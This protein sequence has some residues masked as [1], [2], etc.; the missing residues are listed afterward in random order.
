MH[1]REPCVYTARESYARKGPTACT[2]LGG[3]TFGTSNLLGIIIKFVTHLNDNYSKLMLVLSLTDGKV[4]YNLLLG[5]VPCCLAKA[6][7][8]S[9]KSRKMPSRLIAA[10]DVRLRCL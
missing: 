7:S 9:K 2:R 4:C 10:V 6:S 5:V 1:E 8:F 3:G